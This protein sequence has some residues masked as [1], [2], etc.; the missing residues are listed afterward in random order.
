MS[1]NH[2]ESN[3]LAGLRSR[4]LDLERQ[5][6]QIP[7][8]PAQ[9]VAQPGLHI[10]VEDAGH[11]FAVGQAV[12]N[13]GFS[14]A[15]AD[16]TRDNVAVVI[17]VASPDVFWVCQW[18]LAIIPGAS[19]TPNTVYYLGTVAGTPT[20]SP[21]TAQRTLFIAI[22]AE[23]IL[24]TAPIKQAASGG[25][26]SPI[27]G[28]SVL[29]K[30]TA[31]TG[32]PAAITAAADDT[33]FGRRSGVLTWEKIATAEIADGSITT[34]K[35]SS[36]AQLA[37]ANITGKPTY[38]DTQITGATDTADTTDAGAFVVSGIPSSTVLTLYEKRPRFNAKWLRATPISATA[39][40][41]KYQVLKYDPTATEWFAF[42]L[43]GGTPR[44]GDIA[45]V[46]TAGSTG[47]ALAQAGKAL[48]VLGRTFT[49]DGAPAPIQAG[50][51]TV[52]HRDA[53]GGPLAFSATIVLGK[54]GGG[55]SLGSVKVNASTGTPAEW[56][57]S[58]ASNALQARY[59]GTTVLEAKA[60]SIQQIVCKNTSGTAGTTIQIDW[61]GNS[62][63]LQMFRTD[64]STTTPMVDINIADA[65]LG[66]WTTG[67]AMKIREIVYKD[68]IGN[69]KTITVLASP[70]Y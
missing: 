30:A 14:W 41:T 10:E 24:V 17:R 16:E 69:T 27:S 45:Y 12:Y 33:I 6:R 22:T 19:Y 34:A 52:L 44:T 58:G 67:K 2:R 23:L 61:S 60:G 47:F 13:D 3:E 57:I 28:Q 9:L 62:P 35:L 32:V 51:G 21:G 29:G 56:E 49:S 37:W 70:P 63:R 48:S 11:G 54:S 26:L 53:S 65:P 50:E 64:V 40:T 18:G 55:G 31:G 25:G 36:S 66:G 7:S 59:N 1:L 38:F 42:D 15:L 68:D 8:R 20:I 43:A 46:D 5:V 39:P 4:V